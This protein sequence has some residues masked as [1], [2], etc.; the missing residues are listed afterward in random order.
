MVQQVKDIYPNVAVLS[1][2]SN[3]LRDPN[4]DM[5]DLA[6]LIKTEPSLTADIIKISNSA[7]YSAAAECSEIGSALAR[8]GFNDTQKIVSLIL[9]RD[10]CSKDLEYYGMS[11]DDLLGE[12]MTVSILMEVMARALRLNK[13]EAATIG[14]LHNVGRV[15]INNLLVYMESDS[16]WDP[17]VPINEWEQSAAGFHYGEAGSLFLKQMNFPEESQNVICHHINLEEAPE[18][19]PMFYLL[20]YCVKLGQAVGIG[21]IAEE[22][23][24]PDL[25]LLS[26]YTDLSEN[27]IQIM[28][29]EAQSRYEDI[30][31]EIF[32]KSAL[33][34]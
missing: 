28:V 34:G 20:H 19:N 6:Q 29:M 1:K 5:D 23:K 18:A 21:F 32:R 27:D 7:I 12:S 15:M 4:A 33:A 17:K 24:V 8:I 14:T 22:Y 13:S 16:Y 2:L 9:S 25:E 26:P 11:A 31:R 10:L 30:A 3:L